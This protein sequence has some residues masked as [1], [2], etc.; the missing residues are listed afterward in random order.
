[1]KVG[2]QGERLTAIGKTL[3]A[4]QTT[5]ESTGFLRLDAEGAAQFVAEIERTM[6]TPEGPG[7]WYLSAIHRLANA[8]VDVRVASIEGLDWAEL[9]F[10][11][12]LE[13]TRAITA[14]WVAQKPL[15]GAADYARAAG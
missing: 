14:G 9:D 12:D 6:R 1:M 13:R 7:L 10:P 2:T 8:G 3:S 11:A 15:A 5:G 4:A